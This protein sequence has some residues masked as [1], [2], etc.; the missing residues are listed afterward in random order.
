MRLSHENGIVYV[1]P[2]ADYNAGGT[3]E[4]INTEGCSHVAFIVQ[5]GTLTDN[6][7]A[8]ADLTI[9]SGASDGT[10]TTAETFPYRL[11]EGAQGAASA[12][13]FGDEASAAT[14]EL[15]KAT[16]DSKTLILE[17]PVDEI[18]EGQP[19][20]TL[21]LNADGGSSFIS[22][23]AILMGRRYNGEDAPTAI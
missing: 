15:L 7:G 5:C 11:A 20:L 6:G 1:L 13:L 21:A 18:T 19:W 4:S 23:I 17:V 14:L 9:K 10:Q 16:Y 2:P 8:G 12:D 3:G 22:A